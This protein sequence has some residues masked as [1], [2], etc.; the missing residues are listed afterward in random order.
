[1]EVK[2][3][4]KKEYKDLYLPK[5]APMTIKVPSITYLR[6][7]GTGAPQGENYQEAMQILY[8]LSFTIK[9]SK[10]S[11]QA[12]TGYYEY[13]VPPLE[14]LWDRID[15]PREQWT[16]SSLIRQPEFVTPEV[17]MWAQETAA[18]KK[19]NIPVHKAQ[20]WTYVEGL[21]VQMMH[22]GP[23]S[24]EERSLRKMKAYMEK[25]GLLLDGDFGRRHH[26]IYLSDPRRTKPERLK[27]VLRLPV[28]K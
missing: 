12:P 5:S 11:G 13:V 21:C 15:R 3:D 14:G 2:R 7:D 26:E 22:L 18:K 27:T 25:E 24:E 17:F 8:T 4:F 23:Y 16:W 10:M 20:L 1:M 6:V 28:K 9:M 19:P